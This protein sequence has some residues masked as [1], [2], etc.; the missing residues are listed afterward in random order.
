MKGIGVNSLYY[1]SYSNSKLVGFTYYWYNQASKTSGATT[2][3][4]AGFQFNESGN[5]YYYIAIG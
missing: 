4:L 2:S 3:D 1:G 5:K